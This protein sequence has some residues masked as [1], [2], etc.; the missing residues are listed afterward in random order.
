M[1]SV[2]VTSIGSHVEIFV[3]LS[4]RSPSCNTFEMT[5]TWSS[6]DFE[7]VKAVVTETEKL[8]LKYRTKAKV[9]RW[10]DLAISGL[11]ITSTFAIGVAALCSDVIAQFQYT[12]ALLFLF[13]SALTAVQSVAKFNKKSLFYKG[14]SVSMAAMA[15]HGLHHLNKP[16][17]ER[18]KPATTVIERIQSVIQS[19]KLKIF[20]INANPK[21]FDTEE[22]K[23]L[24]KRGVHDED[25]EVNVATAV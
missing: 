22:L 25:G 19:I 8:T 15:Q 14:A 3:I 18:K 4:P 17:A 6:H 12:S 21:A 2:T 5:C 16:L 9:Y 24:A 7:E 23:L 10:L 11:T 20:H 1:S 13:I